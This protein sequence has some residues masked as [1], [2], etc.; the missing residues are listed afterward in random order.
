MKP[1]TYEVLVRVVLGKVSRWVS[2]ARIC[3]AFAEFAAT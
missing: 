1:Q 2:D 3:N